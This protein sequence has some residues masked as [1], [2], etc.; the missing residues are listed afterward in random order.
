MRGTPHVHCLV[1]IKHDG[2]SPDSA[3]S[4]DPAKISALKEL[5]RKTVSA[6]L[7]SRHESDMNDLPD[8]ACDHELRIKEEKQYNWTPHADYFKDTNDPRRMN[9]NPSLN[10]SRTLSGNFID[11][12]VQACSRRLQIA[13]Q[14]HRC[15]FTCFKYC[16]IDEKICRFC[17]PWPEN[18]NSSATDVIILKDRDKKSRV[19][20]RL[21][22]ERNNGN[23]NA[24]FV[25]PLINCA[26]GGN[27]DV[28]FIMN[29][30]GAAEYAAGY[31]SKAE[32]PDQKKL[33]KIF[34]KSIVNLQ[35]RTPF[36]TDCQ[37]LNAAA[38]AVIGSTQ[39]GAVQA[40]YFILDQ[41]FVISS[42]NIINLNPRKRKCRLI[43][44]KKIDVLIVH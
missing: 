42:R 33:Q 12:I 17:F 9:F 13:N 6:K 23:V 37:R 40:M 8:E 39:V 10:Y 18:I 14:I 41:K 22:P 4:Q 11:P 35:E 34:V 1:C 3:E 7:I 2:L 36:V 15:C 31:A 25:S 21:I 43:F 24:T 20:I 19:R 29:S 32:A 16:P 5:L 27:S 28:Q 44:Q 38:N 26:H 30:H